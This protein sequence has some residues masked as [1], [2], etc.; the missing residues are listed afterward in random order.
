ML[1]DKA[2]ATADGRC[3]EWFGKSRFG[4]HYFETGKSALEI[5]SE[6]FQELLY[7]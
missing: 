6:N 2:A 1:P 3:L 4:G 7:F 5:Y